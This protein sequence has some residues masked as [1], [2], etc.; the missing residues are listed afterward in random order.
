[1]KPP[2]ENLL[3]QMCIGGGGGGGGGGRRG[4][5]G[6]GRGRGGGVCWCIKTCAGGLSTVPNRFQFGVD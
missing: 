6:R 5:G 1:M 2:S 3:Q 4:G